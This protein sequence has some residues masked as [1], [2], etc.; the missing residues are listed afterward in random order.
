MM[1]VVSHSNFKSTIEEI[2]KYRILSLDTETTGLRA[3]HGDTFF[4]VIISNGTET[5]YF[6]FNVKPDIPEKYQL[7]GDQRH[8]LLEFLMSHT[9]LWYLHNAKFDMAMLGF[10]LKGA[11]WDTKVGARLQY[12]DHMNYS[13]ADCAERMGEKKDDGVMSWLIKNG[14]WDW[15]T[16]PGKDKREKAIYFA[17]APWDLIVPYACQDA[18]VTYKLGEHQRHHLREEDKACSPRTTAPRNIVKSEISLLRTVFHMEQRGVLVDRDFCE[19]AIEYERDRLLDAAKRFEEIAGEAFEPGPKLFSRLWPD[20]PK[21]D[22]GNP[23]FDA[24]V[25]VSL[26]ETD[27]RAKMVLL[28]REAKS[29]LNYFHG[30]LYHADHSGFIHT[31]FDQAGTKTGRFSSSSPNLQNLTK[32]DADGPLKEF[33]VRRALIP[34]PGFK[35][36]LKDMDQAE[37]R[38]LLEYAGADGLIEKVLSGLD[39]HQATADIAGISRREAKTANFATLYGSGIPHLASTLG[40][41]Q[42]KAKAIVAAI[43]E[44]APEIR[45]FIR[46]VQDRAT[47]QG[48]ITNWLGRR[49]HCD[50][51]RFAYK[52]PNALIQGGIGDIVKQAMIQCDKFFRDF[53]LASRVLLNIH[54]ELVF[55]IADGEASIIPDIDLICN[56]IYKHRK[57][58][59]TWGSSLAT[60][61]ADKIKPPVPALPLHPKSPG[62]AALVPSHQGL[63]L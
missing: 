3:Y 19:K 48:Y 34:R 1:T 62:P 46:R 5:Y 60:S 2:K 6:N 8:Y 10:C 24:E 58:P 23:C 40:V 47:A 55:E 43:F 18:L 50:D 35:F 42:D 21:T 37:Y 11:I 13:L 36:L 7:N 16:V 25:M 59:L 29:N 44:A 15:V 49:W 27:N 33:S 32:L 38:L 56:G 31:N 63:L 30:F 57:L 17:D 45:S 26:A 39:V 41:T 54:D 20:V 22:K 61:L 12:S 52:A 53:G 9:A 51:P 4:S 14:A 28:A